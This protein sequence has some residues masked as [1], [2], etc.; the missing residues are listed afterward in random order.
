MPL[1]VT[2][3]GVRGARLLQDLN[4]PMTLTDEDLI[5]QMAQ[6]QQDA[7]RELHER[8]APYLYSMGR[9]M[10]RDPSDTE[11]CVQDAFM[12]AWKAAARFDRQ[13]ASAK[14]W[15]VTIAH[16][17]FLQALRDRPDTSLPIEDWDSPTRSPDPTDR[18]LAE[19]AMN[20][21]SGNE[22]RLVELAYYQGH[23]HAEVADLTGIPLGTVKTRLRA[24]LARMKVHLGSVSV[25]PGTGESGTLGGE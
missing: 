6:G 15:L 25:A 13:L 11:S 16:R 8:Y 1:G 18:V 21:L 20:I 7:L 12:N 17:R 9:R 3:L 2:S 14:T 10:L 23:S 24:A 4:L 19:R 22:R 5:A